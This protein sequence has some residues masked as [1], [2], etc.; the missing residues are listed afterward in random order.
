MQKY[1]IFLFQQKIQKFYASD[2][3]EDYVLILVNK[4]MWNTVNELKMFIFAF[5][6]KQQYQV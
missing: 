5:V 3:H 1:K 2:K 6:F 4:N